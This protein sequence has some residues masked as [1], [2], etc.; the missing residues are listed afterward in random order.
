MY[1]NAN[2][3]LPREGNWIWGQVTWELTGNI[4]GETRF[5]LSHRFEHPSRTGERLLNT[6]VRVNTNAKTFHIERI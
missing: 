1:V 6:I 5:Q 2:I 4:S 3:P